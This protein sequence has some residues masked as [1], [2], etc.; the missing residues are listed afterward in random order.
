MPRRI[1]ALTYLVA[2]GGCAVATM[3][4][5]VEAIDPPVDAGAPPQV[6]SGETPE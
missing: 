4:E 6:E 5:P 2:L 1:T 3:D